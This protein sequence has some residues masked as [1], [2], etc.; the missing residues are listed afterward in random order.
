[1]LLAA[2]MNTFFKKKSY[3]IYKSDINNPRMAKEAKQNRWNL[4][5]DKMQVMWTIEANIEG[6]STYKGRGKNWPSHVPLP[7]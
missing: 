6:N 1:M 2:K 4:C 7:C 5:T 3:F